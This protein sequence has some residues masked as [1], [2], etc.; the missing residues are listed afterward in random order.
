MEEVTAIFFSCRRLD[1]LNQTISSF[2]KMNTYPIKEMIIV[3]DSGDRGTHACIKD[4]YPDYTLILHSKNVG[5]IKSIDIG[6][7][8]IK[9]DYIFHCE[10]DWGFYK[11]SFIEPSLELLKRNS[12]IITVWLREQYDTNRHPVETQ[13]HSVGKVTYQYLGLDF[14]GWH[15][16]TFNPGL[17][18]LVDYEEIKPF[19]QF[20]GEEKDSVFTE[21]RIGQAYYRLGYRGVILSTGFVRHL[22]HRKSIRHYNGT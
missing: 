7:S 10:D 15:G 6:Y 3:D 4:T 21:H 22:G 5:L 1:L 16:Y 2:V 9:T 19:S 18:R 20:L 11:P 14:N 13:V 8:H 17:R 12:N